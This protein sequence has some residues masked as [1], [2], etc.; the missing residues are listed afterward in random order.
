MPWEYCILPKT[1]ELTDLINIVD[2]DQTPQSAVSDLRL[3]CFAT[4]RSWQLIMKYFI[5][6]TIILSLPLIQEGQ[7]SVS[8]KRM[9]KSTN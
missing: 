8:G 5:F 6:F 9:C 3:H 4:R 1:V 7:F 2:P